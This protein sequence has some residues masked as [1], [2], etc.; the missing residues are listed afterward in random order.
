M[1]QKLLLLASLIILGLG[2]VAQNK[3]N[4]YIPHLIEKDGR[5][6]LVVD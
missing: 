3:T 6:Q 4:N 5:H 1:K 2:L